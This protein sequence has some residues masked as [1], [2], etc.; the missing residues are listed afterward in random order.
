MSIDWNLYLSRYQTTH[1]GFFFGA[2][3]EDC[4][5]QLVLPQE[6]K[7][8][9]LVTLDEDPAGRYTTRA[10]KAR[11]TVQLN[12]SYELIIHN[13]S[14]TGKGVK[15]LMNLAGRETDFGY[16]EA[17]R[18]RL[19]IT[20]NKPFTKLVLGDLELRN[21]LI[22]RTDD[23]LMVRPS[24]GRTG[25]HVVEV[26][27]PRFEGSFTGYDGWTNQAMRDEFTYM[28]ET[29]RESLRQQG[30]EHFD[31]QLDGLLELLR[32]AQRAV[33]TWNL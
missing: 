32:A 7:A 8:P 14:L 12:D 19:I 5:G 13:R 21:A 28:D 17:T 1:G 3:E 27:A 9:L 25:W 2:D 10:L 15:G 24:P 30:S 29:E 33:T 31:A 6:G 26:G 16:P 23:Y 22:A 11:T 4:D 20:N 18:G